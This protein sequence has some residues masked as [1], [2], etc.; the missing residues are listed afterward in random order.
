MCLAHCPRQLGQCT[1]FVAWNPITY[2]K[3]LYTSTPPPYL[4]YLGG[5]K[6]ESQPK[7]DNPPFPFGK[8]KKRNPS[9]DGIWLR[10]HQEDPFFRWLKVFSDQTP[11]YLAGKKLPYLFVPIHQLCLY[12]ILLS[13][14]SYIATSNVGLDKY[15]PLDFLFQPIFCLCTFDGL[16][17]VLQSQV[18]CFP[19]Q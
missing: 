14:L 5:G 4:I 1:A 17:I 19:W 3:K 8:G 10:K 16:R 7:T 6:R 9:G 11:D 13:V 12:N 2:R 15:A 18:F